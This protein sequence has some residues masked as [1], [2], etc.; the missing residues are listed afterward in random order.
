[1]N[2]IRFEHIPDVGLSLEK[3]FTAEALSDLLA[4]PNQE[5]AFAGLE[6]TQ[7]AFRLE[8]EGCDVLLTAQSIVQVTHPCVR[9]LEPIQIAQTILIDLKLEKPDSIDLIEL[10]REELFLELPAYPACEA[11]CIQVPTR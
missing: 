5:L 11:N 3:E 7:V 9:C 8:K 1:M 2:S 6:P 4:E 10:F